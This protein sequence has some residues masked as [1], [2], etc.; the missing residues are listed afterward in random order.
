MRLLPIV[1]GCALALAGCSGDPAVAPSASPEGGP[2]LEVA[3]LPGGYQTSPPQPSAEVS[4]AS[5]VSVAGCEPLLDAFR[6]GFGDAGPT[7]RFEGGSTGPFLAERLSTGAAALDGQRDLARRCG[8]FTETDAD[9][10]TTT[11]TVAPVADFPALGD[12]S[13]AFRVSAGGGT[14]DD[15]YA[16]SG[17]LVVARQ[18]ATTCTLVHFGQPGVDRAETEAIA[19][20]AVG[21]L[22]RRQ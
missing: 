1:A 14:G 11:V 12:E 15:S 21:K 19:R 3:D 6:A 17:Y 20:S 10:A 4:A 9:G 18:G 8:S 5:S 7:A 2:L 16:L 22:R 13:A